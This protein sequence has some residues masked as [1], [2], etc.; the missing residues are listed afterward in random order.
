VSPRGVRAGLHGTCL[1]SISLASDR[2]FLHVVQRPVRQPFGVLRL[3]ELSTEVLAIGRYHLAPQSRPGAGVTLHRRLCGGRA[4]PLGPGFIGLS[5][6]LPHRSA[7]FGDDPL[8][9]APYQVMNRYVR[10][11]L[12]AGR[13]VGLDLLY[14]G[15]DR[16]TLNRKM[17]ALVSF[18][19]DRAGALLFEAVIANERDFSVLPALLEQ[20]DP[21]GVVKAEMLTPDATTCVAAELGRPLSLSQ[22]AEV[23]REG[24]ETAFGIECLPHSTSPLEAQAIEN[25]ATH[26]FTAER[27]LRPGR[28]RFDHHAVTRTQLG[29]FEAHFTIEQGRFIKEV[30]FAGD[31]IA[32]SQGIEELERGL[33]LCPAEWRA[34]DAVAAEVFAKPENFILGIGPVHVIADTISRG[35][36]A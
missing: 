10:G 6:I 19:I 18:E 4:I 17:L 11:L 28:H 7:L 8:L 26:E 13:Q 2:H 9:L 1:P 35:L 12:T 30:T 23:L 3:Y 16:V 14:P 33:R 24:Y 15:R 5:L 29:V 25:I 20:A 31:F 21:D 34:I 22:L 27:W 32:N 36:P